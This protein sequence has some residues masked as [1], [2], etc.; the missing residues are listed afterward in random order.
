MIVTVLDVPA[1]NSGAT[2][3]RRNG[4]NHP[5]SHFNGDIAH[6]KG[7]QVWLVQAALAGRLPDSS[8]RSEGTRA[9]RKIS[10]ADPFHRHS[11]VDLASASS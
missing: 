2:S 5:P 3:F 7:I 10:A 8:E 1:S 11:V 9:T 4:S 6:S